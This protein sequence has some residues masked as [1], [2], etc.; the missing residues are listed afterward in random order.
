M[1]SGYEKADC[2][3]DPNSGWAAPTRRHGRVVTAIIWV[4]LMTG[5]FFTSPTAAVIRNTLDL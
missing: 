4:T 5:W 2:G 3:I 1:A